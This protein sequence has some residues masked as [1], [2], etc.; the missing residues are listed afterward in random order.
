VISW[1][2]ARSGLAVDAVQPPAGGRAPGWRA[3]VVVARRPEEPAGEIGRAAPADSDRYG[4]KNPVA[5]Y[6]LPLAGPV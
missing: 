2:T 3:G 6:S 1:L 5:V 4:V